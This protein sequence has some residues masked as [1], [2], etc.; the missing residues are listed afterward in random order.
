MAQAV[1]AAAGV[2]HVGAMV[3]AHGSH[4]SSGG[5]LQAADRAGGGVS[6]AT[7]T[8]MDDDDDEFDDEETETD[9]EDE[10]EGTA[11]QGSGQGCAGGGQEGAGQKET[12]P[13]R[14]R[15][16]HSTRRLSIS[17]TDCD[18]CKH[19]V[20]SGTPHVQVSALCAE[21]LPGYACVQP[22]MFR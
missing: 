18:A 12:G 17:A 1:A 11:G 21:E 13:K 3:H 10:E 6:T 2:A 7:G 9:K 16:E 4:G 14:K 8:N 20:A 5:T 19:V 22:G 15:G